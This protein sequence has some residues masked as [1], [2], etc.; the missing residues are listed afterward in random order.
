[1]RLEREVQEEYRPQMLAR[2]RDKVAAQDAALVGQAPRCPVHDRAMKSRGRKP[3]SFTTRYGKVELRPATYRCNKKDCGQHSRPLMERLGV[4]AGQVSGALL[5][6]LALLG[7]VVPYELAAQLAYLFFGTPVSAMT[8]WW[9]VQ[10]LGEAAERYAKQQGRL[11]A[12]PNHQQEPGCEG[13]AAVLLG[14]DGCMLGMQVRQ[15]RRVHKPNQKL[16]PLPKVEQGQFREVKT[17]VVLLP[18]ERVETSPGR[19]SVLRR[20]LVTCLG[21][22][23]EIFE[24]L[25][26]KLNELGWMG[27]QTVVVIVADGAEWIWNRAKMFENRCEILDF[28]HAVE[29]AWKFARVHYGEASQQANEFMDRL[30]KDLRQGRVNDVLAQLKDRLA[31]FQAMEVPPQEPQE[32]LVTLIR[33]YTDHADRMRYD[34]YLRLG[35]GIGSGAAESS[36][37]QMVHARMRQAGMRWSEVGAQHLLALRALLLNGQW[38]LVDRLALPRAAA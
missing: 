15:E 8:V 18:Q 5:R 33:Y 14:V 12:D 21:H 22:A 10:R 17:G 37:K 27:P 34:D 25:W 24:R 32:A 11:F 6:L 2:L 28:W 19:K 31:Q 23:D 35:Y 16:P 13:P 26:A 29:C 36:H 1:M 7:V 30:A 4:E 20:A 9:A 38:E 3:C